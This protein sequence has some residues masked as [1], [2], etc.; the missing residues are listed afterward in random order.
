MAEVN[1]VT[2]LKSKM[3]E[4]I[5]VGS[6]TVVPLWAEEPM[7]LIH[8]QTKPSPTEVPNVSEEHTMPKEVP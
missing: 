7:G 5:T 8:L 2:P 3:I 1:I 4:F 6:R